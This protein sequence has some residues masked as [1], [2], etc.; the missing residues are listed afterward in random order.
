MPSIIDMVEI[1]QRMESKVLHVS[2]ANCSKVR[3][4]NASCSR[5]ADACP[6]GSITL[7]DNVIDID[8]ELC[9]ECGAC[10]AACPT[11]T[12][13]FLKPTDDELA[14]ALDAS[15]AAL[16]GQAVVTC[17]RVSAHREANVDVVC[18]VQCLARMD[19]SSLLG[20]FARGAKSV[21]LVGHHCENCKYRKTQAQV[22]ATISEVNML[23]DVWGS[24]ARA[25]RAECVPQP[26]QAQS[27]DQGTG[28]VS[29]RGFFS[30]MKTNVKGMAT[31]A[32]TVTIEKE[33]GIKHDTQ[34]LRSMLKV[35]GDGNLPRIEPVHHDAIMESLYEL[36]EAQ[37]DELIEV[38]HW[39]DVRLESEKCD[40]C[41][42]CATFCPAGALSKVYEVDEKASKNK[43]KA[44]AKIS[45]MEFRLADC[46]QC[47]LCQDVCMKR[48][49]TVH[50]AVSTSRIME[51]EPVEM[52]G[53][54]KK[55]TRF[56]FS[57]I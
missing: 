30:E 3:N 32:A 35:G 27:V 50:S 33:L 42:V 23:M 55:M 39:G 4:R 7:H 29:R 16:D 36:G 25:Q 15:A 11:S 21:T 1:M 40:N 8:S 45:G 5:C 6:S 43:N 54:K 48:A 22:D 46:L 12:I 9:M 20:A 52:R 10:A 49:I 53:T 31:E 47:R 18:E 44:T 37:R 28:G 57:S 26:A 41:G 17:A 34:S 14:A 38:S 56:G 51:F 19:A 24:S 13:A 2:P